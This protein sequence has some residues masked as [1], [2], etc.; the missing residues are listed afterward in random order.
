[1]TTTTSL[2]AREMQLLSALAESPAA[3]QQELASTI[4]VS[5]RYVRLLL[6]REPVK[7]ALD[8][9]AKDAIRETAALIARG[10]VR[11]ARSLIGMSDGTIKPNAARVGACRATLEYLVPLTELAAIFPRLERL[12]AGRREAQVAQRGGL[13]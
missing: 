1:M 12:E 6:A 13:Q 3:T 9:A 5:P 11:A 2:N 8:V 4:G 10:A 7:A